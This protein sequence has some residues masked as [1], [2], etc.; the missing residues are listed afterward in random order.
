METSRVFE[1]GIRK[2]IDGYL[3]NEDWVQEVTTGNYRQWMAAQYSL[4][5]GE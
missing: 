2:T 4:E 3:A 5:T 1:T